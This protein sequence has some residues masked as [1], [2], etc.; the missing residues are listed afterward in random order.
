MSDDEDERTMTVDRDHE[1]NMLKDWEKELEIDVRPT[2]SN[3]ILL[4]TI[5]LQDLKDRTMK[6]QFSKSSQD[7]M[8][9][10]RERIHQ[11]QRDLQDA[12]DETEYWKNGLREL[13]A[14]AAWGIDGVA[15]CNESL[16]PDDTW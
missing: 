6:R 15:I 13:I 7:Y 11:N 3:Y 14:R 16:V 4:K 8:D 10:L 9:D 1:V 2:S 5:L 12:K